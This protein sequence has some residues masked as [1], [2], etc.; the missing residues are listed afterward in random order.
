[1]RGEDFHTDTL[2]SIIGMQKGGLGGTPPKFVYDPPLEKFR[3]F[4][5]LVDSPWYVRPP[6]QICFWL[7]QRKIVM[8]PPL[9]FFWRTPLVLIV[10]LDGLQTL[11]KK[12]LGIA[13]Y[14]RLGIIPMNSC[15]AILFQGFSPVCDTA[16]RKMWI[17]AWHLYIYKW[18]LFFF[19]FEPQDLG[20]QLW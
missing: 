6:R 11:R 9:N 20:N 7:P 13:P 16:I 10:S 8:T 5:K 17:L 19:S 2:V 3:F 15:Q 14:K 12:P 4:G 18:E 1:M